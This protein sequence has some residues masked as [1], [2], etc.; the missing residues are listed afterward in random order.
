MGTLTWA[1]LLFTVIVYI[2]S[3]LFR[4]LF[5]RVKKDNIY[6]YF[7]SVPRSMLTTFRCSFG[8]CSS[9]GGMPIFEHVHMEYGVMASGLYC[10]FVFSVTIGLFNV[11]S[12][13][14]VERTMSVALALNHEKKVARLNNSALWDT[15]IATVIHRL[16]DLSGSALSFCKMSEAVD[17]VIAMEVPNKVLDGV[18]H[19]S[20]VVAALN[21]LDIDPGDHQYLSDILDPDN[22]G[23][24]CVSELVDGL[25][26]LRGDPRRSDIVT[27]DLM[28]RSMQRQV[29]A[30]DASVAALVEQL[31]PSRDAAS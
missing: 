20:V 7:N 28:V 16:I 15:R 14:F 25:R 29:G 22:S 8:D 5:G 19:D 21:D 27:V 6:E 2:T 31:L 4:E 26:R 10:L 30:I 11:I 13:I 3:L 9:A 1:L 24:V 17:E 18:L 12:A 23:G